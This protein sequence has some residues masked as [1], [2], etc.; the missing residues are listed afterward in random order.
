MVLT[1]PLKTVD[2][3]RIAP[4]PA[5]A[6]LWGEEEQQRTFPKEHPNR[7]TGIAQG[8]RKESKNKKGAENLF[9]PQI[10]TYYCVAF[11]PGI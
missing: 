2:G 4:T 5:R 6:L 1:Y 10:F 11:G 8:H 9:P 3:S 7:F